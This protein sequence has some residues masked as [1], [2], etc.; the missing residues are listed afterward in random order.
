[1]TLSLVRDGARLD[2]PVVRET[3]RIE[4]VRSRMLE[5]D[6]SRLLAYIRITTFAESTGRQVR[7]QLAPLLAQGAKG[8]IL[9]VRANPGGYLSAAVEVTSGFLRDGVVLYEQRAAG[10]GRRPYRTTG[11]PQAPDLPIVVLVD[12]GSASA[13]EIVAAALRDNQRALLVGERTFGKGTV[14][15]VRPLSDDSQLH[16]TVAQ[17]LT[18]AGHA[19]QG[20]GLAPDVEVSAVEGRD[21]PLDAA[22]DYLIHGAP[23]G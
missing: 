16:V 11:S 9:D 20:E 13:A 17:W 2:V 23:R 6:P 22:A 12:R 1:V 8:V 3:I 21:A 4:S 18:P 19:I 7:E 10:D 5:A 15:E 14:Q